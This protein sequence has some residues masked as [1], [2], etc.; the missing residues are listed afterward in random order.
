VSLLPCIGILTSIAALVILILFLV[1]IM[2]LKNQVGS[3]GPGGFPMTP[4]P[5]GA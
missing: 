4:N 5:P 2:G 1:K 3:A